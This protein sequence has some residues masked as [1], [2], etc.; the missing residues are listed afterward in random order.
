MHLT[1]LT[2]KRRQMTASQMCSFWRFYGCCDFIAN[3]HLM[4]TEQKWRYFVHQNVVHNIQN[5]LFLN[6]PLFMSSQRKLFSKLL[7]PSKCK[8][9]LRNFFCSKGGKEDRTKTWNKFHPAECFSSLKKFHFGFLHLVIK[10]MVDG[11]WRHCISTAHCCLTFWQA[12]LAF[13]CIIDSFLY[14]ISCQGRH[15]LGRNLSSI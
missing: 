13:P 8:Q 1:V 14:Q 2:S 6:Q 15:V 3:H 12:S 5:F 10:Q 11:S 7:S 9:N 4:N